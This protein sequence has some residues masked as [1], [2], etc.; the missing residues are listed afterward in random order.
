MEQA[1]QV[2]EDGHGDHLDAVLAAVAAAAAVARRV[3]GRARP[4]CPRCEGWIHSVREEPWRARWG[5]PAAADAAESAPRSRRS[6]ATSTPSGRA[7]SGRR[8]TGRRS[9]AA[10]FLVGQAP[11]PHEARLGRP[12][13]W[14]AGKTLFRWLGEATRA[15]EERVRERVYIAAVVRCFP[16]KARGGGDRVPTPAEVERW[17][18]F[19]AREVEILRPALVLPVG[20]LAISEVLG[21]EAPLAEVVGERAAA[22]LPRRGGRRDP[23]PAPVGRLDLVQ[24]GAGAHAARAGARARRG[25]PGG[26]A[27]VREGPVSGARGAA[28]AVLLGLLGAA[29]AHAPPPST[30]DVRE[31]PRAPPAEGPGAAAR[32][33]VGVASYYGHRFHGRRTASGAR[34]DMHALT[35]A[36]PTRRSGRACAS[37]RSSA[38]RSVVV[39]VNS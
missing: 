37:P 7:A 14:T 29:C 38:G 23:A 2:V 27:R 34:Y 16:G 22:R 21:R 18:G 35:C 10:I 13:A 4:T 26:R 36:H 15:D 33:E 39:T 11:G 17:R 9:R 5:P 25:P 1:A 8:C 30:G 31:T 28:A 12:F 24:D 3:P 20:R 19:L 32:A 6:T